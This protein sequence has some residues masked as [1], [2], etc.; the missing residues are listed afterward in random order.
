MPTDAPTNV[1]TRVELYRGPLGA[2]L[3]TFLHES[4]ALY[5]VNAAVLYPLGIELG[6]GRDQDQRVIGLTLSRDVE[7]FTEHEHHEGM[8][9][10]GGAGFLSAAARGVRAGIQRIDMRRL[11]EGDGP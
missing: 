8:S 11:H 2:E 3:A 9:R 6:V 7:P 1:P 5:L 4:G 10:L